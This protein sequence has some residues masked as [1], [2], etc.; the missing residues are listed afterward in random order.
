VPGAQSVSFPNLI[1]NAPSADPV[2]FTTALFEF[3]A[4]RQGIWRQRPCGWCRGGARG[5]T[6]GYCPGGA[7]ARCRGHFEPWAGPGQN[8]SMLTISRGGKSG[9]CAV[10]RWPPQ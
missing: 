9:A 4:K 7:A 8:L 2:A 10:F 5:S 3:L 1:H 6:R